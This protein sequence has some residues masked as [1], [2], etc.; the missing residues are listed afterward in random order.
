VRSTLKSP[1]FCERD[2]TALEPTGLGLFKSGL[3][4]LADL[5]DLA[6]TSSLEYATGGGVGSSGNLALE[7][8]PGVFLQIGGSREEGFGVRVVGTREDALRRSHFHEPAEIHHGDPIR[9]VTD[10][11]EVVGDEEIGHVLLGLELRQQVDDRSL[12]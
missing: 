10:H 2:M 1:Q 7:A 6:G 5:A 3:D 4:R 8:N 12:D 9:Q 11:V